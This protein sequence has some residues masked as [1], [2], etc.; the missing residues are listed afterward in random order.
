MLDEHRKWAMYLVLKLIFLNPGT[1]GQACNPSTWE[2]RQEDLEFEVIFVYIARSPPDC[3][4]K[5]PISQNKSKVPNLRAGTLPI[6]K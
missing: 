4:S 3:V 1:V 2:V 5:D 6:Q